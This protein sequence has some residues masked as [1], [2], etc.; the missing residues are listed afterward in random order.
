MPSN[1]DLAVNQLMRRVTVTN[2][3]RSY[4]ISVSI[5]LSDPERA[6]S[7][8]NAVAL[9]YLRGQLL[10]QVTEAYAAAERELADLSSIYGALHPSYLNGQAK[11]ERLQVR[12]NDLRDGMLS[13]DAVRHVVGQSFVAAEKVLVPTDPNIIL[14]LG[15]SAAA[16][17]VS[18]CCCDRLLE[19][20]CR[21]GRKAPLA[22]AQSTAPVVRSRRR[23]SAVRAT[24]SKG[25]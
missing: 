8:A 24:V 16:A 13:E 2:D 4:L 9:E 6:A 21:R 7:L 15:L 12:L 20:S 14:I 22:A 18:R 10:Q 5:T 19:R 25:Y 17:L 1:Y 3:P 23:P 11:L